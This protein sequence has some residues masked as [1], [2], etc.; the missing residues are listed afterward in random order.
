MKDFF[1]KNKKPIFIAAIILVLV[2]LFTTAA[3]S[4]PSVISKGNI[5]DISTCSVP[6]G[7]IVA[8]GIDISVYQGN[9]DFE[10]VK[11]S[12]FSFVIIKAGSTGFGADE[13]F[14]SYYKAAQDA[15]LDIGCYYYTYSTTVEGVKADA[16]EL[17]KIIKGKTFTYPVFLDLEDE[18]I[19]SAD[20]I[21][22][23]TGMINAFCK[24]IKRKGYYPGVYTSTSVY[25][26]YIE[27][28]SLVNSWDFW[29][30]SYD[31][32]TYNSD[33]YHKD[34]SMW[35]YS[36]AGVVNGIDAEVDLDVSYVDYP[37]L[38]NEFRDKILKLN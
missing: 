34:F 29:I 9:I 7:K 25:Y 23:N 1:T 2:F 19:Q 16:D 22:S 15:G 8:H 20:M 10:K 35:Q 14:E 33:A 17:L 24:Q 5:D 38:I 3:I 27:S 30:A 21:E 26:N 18:N 13:N 6:E 12:G 4:V 28:D 37:K 32:H 11:E 31:D 36:N